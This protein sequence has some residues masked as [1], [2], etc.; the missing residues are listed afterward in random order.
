MPFAPRPLSGRV[1]R[2]L[3]GGLDLRFTG[4]WTQL[5]D[6]PSMWP[7]EGKVGSTFGER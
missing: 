4:D 2:A 3:E 7:V 5:A 6:A 1:S